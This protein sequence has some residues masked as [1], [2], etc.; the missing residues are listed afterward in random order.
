MAWST[1]SRQSRGY[2]AAWERVR[3]VILKRDKGM[4]QPCRRAG[5]VV[6]GPIVDHITPKAQ[7]KRLGWTQAQ[8]DDPGNLQCICQRCHDE[9]T[10]AETGRTYLPPKPATGVDGWPVE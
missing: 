2:G 3:K 8:Q 1:E 5:R 10:A 7:A 6:A 9:K 4:C